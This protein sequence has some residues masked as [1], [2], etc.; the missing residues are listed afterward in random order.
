MKWHDGLPWSGLKGRSRRNIVQPSDG[1]ASWASWGAFTRFGACA[2][3]IR[4]AAIHIP[5]IIREGTVRSPFVPPFA[6]MAR[7]IMTAIA[8]PEHKGI[9]AHAFQFSLQTETVNKISTI[10]NIAHPPLLL[11]WND[12]VVNDVT[13]LC[14]KA[15]AVEM[16]NHYM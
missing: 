13:S 7:P 12:V 8:T 10:S 14:S 1:S 2:L 15:Y 9:T 16:R 6:P 3:I 5:S 11:L 4:R